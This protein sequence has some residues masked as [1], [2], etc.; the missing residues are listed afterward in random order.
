MANSQWEGKLGVR[1]PEQVSNLLLNVLQALCQNWVWLHQIPHLNHVWHFC[2]RYKNS[3]FGEVSKDSV[4]SLGRVWVAAEINL[5]N[6]GLSG[7]PW[8]LCVLR[9]PCPT[10]QGWRRILNAVF[11][12]RQ[13]DCVEFV[14]IELKAGFFIVSSEAISFILIWCILST[15]WTFPWY[16]GGVG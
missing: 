6:L 8:L 11:S 16:L 10:E 7:K 12:T 2:G 9:V 3:E 13:K 1:I 14:H 15:V 4:L 5:W